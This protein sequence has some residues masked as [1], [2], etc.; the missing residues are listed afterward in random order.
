MRLFYFFMQSIGSDDLRGPG[1]FE[2]IIPH[3]K[4]QFEMGHLS[5]GFV[6]NYK[7]QESHVFRGFELKANT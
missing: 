2:T 7:A 1:K 6:S 4:L 3:L 5:I